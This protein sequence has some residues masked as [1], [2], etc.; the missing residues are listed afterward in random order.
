MNTT[1]TFSTKSSFVKTKNRLK[2]P[3][4][5]KIYLGSVKKNLDTGDIRGNSDYDKL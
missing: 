1:K 2:S 3:N 4:E 5:P